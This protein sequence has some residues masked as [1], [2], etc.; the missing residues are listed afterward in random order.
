MCVLGG[1]GGGTVTPSAILSILINYLNW[2]AACQDL[3]TPRQDLDMIYMIC[4][5]QLI[6]FMEIPALICSTSLT[7]ARD[8]Q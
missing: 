5:K 6:P 2:D 4:S 1:G 3:I 7:F 8:M